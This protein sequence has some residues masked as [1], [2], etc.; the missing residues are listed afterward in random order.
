MNKKDTD[1]FLADARKYFSESQKA[2]ADNRQLALEDIKFENGD[3]WLKSEDRAGRPC[4]VVNKVAGTVK[5]IV[6]DARQNRPRIKV[7][8]VD[9]FAD[10]K[11]AELYTGLIRNIENLS[12]A[13][14]AYDTGIEQAVRGGIGYWRVLT[15]Y[16]RDD[17]F[18]QDILI[19]RI[20]NPFSVWYDQG[21]SE[22][23]FSDAR[24]CF[25]TDV[26][27]REEFEAKYP[28]ANISEWEKGEGDTA[29]WFSEDSVR[30]AEYFYKEPTTKHL[31]ELIDGKTIEV[32]KPK[33]L[34]QPATPPQQTID[35]NTG[36]P[37]MMPGQPEQDF[38]TGEGIDQPLP[39]KRERK[40]KCHRVMWAKITGTE[41]LEGPQEWAGKYIPI[42]PCLGEEI[43]IEGKRVLRSALRHAKDPQRIYN[44]TRA[45][46][47]E[48]MALGPKQ[49]YI[50]TQKMFEGHEQ[51]WTRAHL[52]PMPYLLANIDGGTLPQRQQ[53]DIST[54][55][56]SNES[57]LAADDIK[58]ATGIYS[59]SL[60]AQGNE[61][62]GKA[63]IARQREGDQATF[64]FSDN[65]SRAVKYTGRI[66]V[67]LIPKIYDTER[68]V[69]LM[70]DDLRKSMQQTPGVRVSQ[71]GT[72][73]WAK[74]NVLDPATGRVVANDLS[75]GKYDVV[76]DAGP[77]YNT[78]RMEAADGMVQLAQAAPQFSPI[79]I[80]R[81]A[82]NLDWPDAQE[83]G[84][85]IKKATQP[86]PP[87]QQPPDPMM[88]LEM[89]KGKMDLQSKQ[90]DIQGKVIEL[91]GKA[92]E[93]AQQGQEGDQRTYQIA[94]KAA[95]DVLRQVMGGR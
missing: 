77:G 89:A 90:L 78:R 43:F 41:I 40:V 70:G 72:S 13:D 54:A 29:G 61:T 67:D 48:I 12:D 56:I 10:P 60:G 28:K 38:V 23:D 21:A 93:Q 37:V 2:E 57:M 68:V 39:F 49:P 16:S 59:A 83:I 31:F 53:L 25:V 76:V 87:Q 33:I 95:M 50:G 8:P 14:S 17:T 74:I 18:D 20:I 52:R 64:V 19:R 35:P 75:A 71:D 3:Q 92:Q 94:A 11:V 81:I 85:E 4:P 46:A 42:V 88:Q 1:Q 15:D 51:M 80:P 69:R 62:S 86:P 44:W 7:R 73:A 30:I 32:K 26:L 45:N 24:Y 84:E 65:Q 27:T 36:Q 91:K 5:Q 63:I 47:I 22:A 82:M 58:A 34:N 79:L 55:G 66:L 6:G 9:S